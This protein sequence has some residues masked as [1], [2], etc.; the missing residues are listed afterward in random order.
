MILIALRLADLIAGPQFTYFGN[1][2]SIP[3]GGWILALASGNAKT[4]GIRDRS[5]E[6]DADFDIS[7]GGRALLCDGIS[8]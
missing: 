2:P 8:V 1:H 3:V 6:A 4:G 7:E 5:V